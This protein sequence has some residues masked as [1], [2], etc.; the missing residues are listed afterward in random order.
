MIDIKHFREH[1]ELY[2]Q[3][4]T[5][6]GAKVD[7]AR[8]RGLDD[9]RTKLLAQ[10]EPMRGKLNVKDRPNEAELTGLQQTKQALERLEAAY[11]A[12][13]LNYQKLIRLVPNLVAADVPV[14]SASL[15]R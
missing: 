7:L 13:D 10:I 5:Q 15:G 8:L 1:P 3:S 11:K 4:I 6:R 2:Q 14:D 12:V 9:D